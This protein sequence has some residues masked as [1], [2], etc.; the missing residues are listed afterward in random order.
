MKSPYSSLPM[1][2]FWRTGVAE[3]SPLSLPRIYKKK[4]PIEQ[5]WKIATAGSCFAQHISRNLRTRGLNV[6]DAEPAPEGMPESISIKYGYNQYSAR[7]GNIYTVSQLL[8]LIQEAGG[9]FEPNH[10]IWKK[11]NR[12]FDSQRPS[13]EPEGFETEREL[14]ANRKFHLDRVLEMFRSMDLFI[15]TLGLTETFEDIET[16][17]A[18]P[19][20][21]GTI[22]GEFDPS[23]FRFKNYNVFEVLEGFESFL[24]ILRKIRNGSL[25]KILLTVSPVPL[26][27]T[28]SGKHV[29]SATTYSKSVLRSVSGY[30]SSKYDFIDY[31]PS[32]E[33]IT[34]QAARGI[35]YSSNLR[36][37]RSESVKI[38]MQH[39]FS[40]HQFDAPITQ[41]SSVPG[42]PQR[43]AKQS[44]NDL[45]RREASED[46]VVC[47]EILLEAFN[48]VK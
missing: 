33:I 21:P 30:L 2:S 43:S 40:E 7:F 17:T 3:A 41:S 20:A 37:V 45:E 15:F 6:I 26:T 28:G 32:Y 18:Y 35:N 5:G 4:W 34:N 42:E 16:G 13:V 44:Q 12:F 1:E 22:A 31:F 48:S 25:P 38:V 39:F 14:I 46:Y 10:L 23:I 29:L 27:A 9:V 8:Q 11:G 47:E 24:E 36:S 19:T